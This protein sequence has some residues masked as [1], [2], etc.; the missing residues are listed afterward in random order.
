MMASSSHKPAFVGGHNINITMCSDTL[1]NLDSVLAIVDSDVATTE[2]WSI[3]SAASH[4][5]SIVTCSQNST[6]L[7]TNALGT[8]YHPGTGYSGTDDFVVLVKDCV[9]NKDTTTVHMTVNN[10]SLGQPRIYRP[11]PPG[12]SVSPNPNHGQ[13]MINVN[14]SDPE[15]VVHITDVLGIQVLQLS[16]ATNQPAALDFKLAPGVYMATTTTREGRYA[17]RIVIQ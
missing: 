5:T 9:G 2:T 3:L 7:T 13:L 17:Q 16:I 6:G 10:C 11:G 15:A 12:I 1:I 8:F 14:S 4:G